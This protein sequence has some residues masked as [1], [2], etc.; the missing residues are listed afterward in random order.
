MLWSSFQQPSL[1]AAVQQQML[2]FDLHQQLKDRWQ[3]LTQAQRLSAA[4]RLCGT[5]ATV[6]QMPKQTPGPGA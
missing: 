2:A 6:L 4:T 5:D 1:S 3:L